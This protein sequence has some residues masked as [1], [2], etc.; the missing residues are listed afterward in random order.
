M[1][2]LQKIAIAKGGNAKSLH[3]MMMNLLED[4]E[5]ETRRIAA[6]Q[7]KG[8]Y[9][10]LHYITHGRFNVLQQIIDVQFR[11]LMSSILKFIHF[12]SL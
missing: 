7:F 3:M 11:V 10:H 1:A 5:V 4:N 12:L 2:D 8:W 6:S 9:H